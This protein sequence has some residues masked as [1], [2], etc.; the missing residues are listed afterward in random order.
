MRLE[1]A[2]GERDIAPREITCVRGDA[3]KPGPKGEVEVIG[4]LAVRC[5]DTIDAE[6]PLAGASSCLP[7]KPPMMP[8]RSCELYMGMRC[9][10]DTLFSAKPVD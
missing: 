5:S 4:L 9:S 10:S 8:Y 2:G 7:A 3:P 1:A 6:Y